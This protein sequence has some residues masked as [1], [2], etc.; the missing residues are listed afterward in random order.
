MR[1]LLDFSALVA[2][3]ISPA[4]ACAELPEDT[5][6]DCEWISPDLPSTN[7][8]KRY[9]DFLG[10]GALLP[11]ILGRPQGYERDNRLRAFQDCVLF[12]Q[13]QKT[14]LVALTASMGDH[15]ILLQLI[16]ASIPVLPPA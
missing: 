16:S 10:R 7:S 14:G 9:V 12:I 13:A 5:L 2:V 3:Y 4:G 6:S 15:D 1:V 8:L 11:G